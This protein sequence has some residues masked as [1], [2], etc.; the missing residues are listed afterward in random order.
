MTG[1]DLEAFDVCR[2]PAFATGR[3]GLTLTLIGFGVT[4]GWRWLF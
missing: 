1:A 3:T 4:Q 2:E